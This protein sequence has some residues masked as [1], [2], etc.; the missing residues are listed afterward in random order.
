MFTTRSKINS[1]DLVLLL[2]R[3]KW[4]HLDRPSVTTPPPRPLRGDAYYVSDALPHNRIIK[5]LLST[6]YNEWRPHVSLGKDAPNRRPIERFGNIVAHSI[7]G[8]LHHRYARI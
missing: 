2:S 5:E 7:L 4:V 6:Y 8:G 1:S 3:G